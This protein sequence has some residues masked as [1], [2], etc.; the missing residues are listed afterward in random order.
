MARIGRSFPARAVIGRPRPS[1]FAGTGALAMGLVLASSAS[2][3]V[4]PYAPQS[5]VHSQAVNRAGNFH[6][7]PKGPT[8]LTWPPLPLTPPSML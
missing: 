3:V 2:T 1:G 5:R 8:W 7:L 4:P 6:H